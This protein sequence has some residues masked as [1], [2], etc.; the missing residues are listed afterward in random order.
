MNQLS[1]FTRRDVLRLGAAASVAPFLNLGAAEEVSGKKVRIALMGLG[2]YATNQ[3]GPAI[4]AAKNCEVAGIVTGSPE[5]IPEWQEKYEIPDGNVYNYENFDE[6]ADNDE[7]DAVYVVTPTGRHAEDTIR[8]LEADKHLIC[9]KPMAPT[10]EDCTRMIKAAEKAGKTLHIGYRLHWE[11]HNLRLMEAMKKKEFGDWK[12]IETA[13]GYRM[14]NF[15]SRKNQ[16]RIRPEMSIAGAL[17][18]MGVYA[19]QGALY[20]A[21]MHPLRV[22][23]TKSTEREDIFKVPE[24]YQWTLEFPGDRQA[25]G[26][27]SYGQNGS[28]LWV[29]TEQ[30][31]IEVERPYAYGGQSGR[32]PEGPMELPQ[33][34]Q[35]KLQVE[36]QAAGILKNEASR[37]PGEMGRRDIRVIRGIVEAAD[38]GEV[39]EFGDFLY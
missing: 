36:G 11:P 25:T 37:V 31:E 30:G 33:V 6:I 1:H 22:R 23:A 10:V 14:T 18:D 34:N 2:D 9:E 8:G 3:L 27:S 16:W 15:D 13:N 38:S 26:S 39:Y 28:K 21:Q 35:Q 5:K 7:I 32:T 12:A 17:Y 24:T 19:V 4:K 20:S 29:E